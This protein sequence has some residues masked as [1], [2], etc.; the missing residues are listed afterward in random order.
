MT[1]TRNRHRMSLLQSAVTLPTYTE[2]TQ[3]FAI[4]CVRNLLFLLFS[5]PREKKKTEI[6][7]GSR[8]VTDYRLRDNFG[9]KPP[10]IRLAVVTL[11]L[12]YCI[13]SS[14]CRHV[15][16]W[17]CILDTPVPNTFEI[18]THYNAALYKPCPHRLESR[19]T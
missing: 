18:A 8:V 14:L 2:Q 15:L 13:S 17:E 3:T 1:T 7:P 9:S 16:P 6:N 19:C 12:R 11:E 4:S 10:K 5:D